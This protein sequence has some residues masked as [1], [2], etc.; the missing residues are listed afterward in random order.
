M[1]TVSGFFQRNCNDIASNATYY[2]VY[3]ITISNNKEPIPITTD[4]NGYF[5]FEAAKNADI[6]YNISADKNINHAFCHIEFHG[7]SLNL[8]A[9]KEVASNQLILKLKTN[10]ILTS[11]DTIKYAFRYGDMELPVHGPITKDT[12]IGIYTKSIAPNL[13]NDNPS[14]GEL[15]TLWWS[16]NKPTVGSNDTQVDYTIHGCAGVADTAYIVVP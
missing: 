13:Y 2:I 12:I 15:K 14:T 8:M 6:W 9:L 7:E 1:V 5:S 16:L 10:H 3:P 11:L 4:A